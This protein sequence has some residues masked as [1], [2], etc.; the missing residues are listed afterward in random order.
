LNVEAPLR[1]CTVF[2]R[3]THFFLE[4]KMHKRFD[5]AL[6]KIATAASLVVLVGPAFA[7]QY[8]L[9][10]AVTLPLTSTDG[11]AAATPTTYTTLSSLTQ[12]P[13]ANNP[14]GPF[15]SMIVGSLIGTTNN[16][17]AASVGTAFAFDPVN[18]FR[19]I[20]KYTVT[21]KGGHTNPNVRA[22]NNVGQVVGT[23][24]IN[25][26]LSSDS[27]SLLG[28]DTWLYSTSDG[29]NISLG[30]TGPNF[31]Y[32]KTVPANGTVTPVGFSAPFSTSN[33]SFL[34]NLGQVVGTTNRFAGDS[35]PTPSTSLGTSAWLYSPTSATPITEVGLLDSNHEYNFV[36]G[37]TSG[38]FSTN[39]VAGFTDTGYMMGSATAFY[40]VGNGTGTNL[41]SDGWV[42]NGSTTTGIGLYL[43]GIAP[44][45]QSGVPDTY[46]YYQTPTTGTLGTTP[47]T[48]QTRGSTLVGI[49][50]AGQVIGTS[51]YYS[52]TSNGFKGSDAFV[53]S[54][55]NGTYRQLG[56]F[57]NGFTGSA[58]PVG[59]TSYVS[60]T[61]N[62]TSTPAYIN[63]GG[64]IV[65]TSTQYIYYNQNNVSTVSSGQ[66]AWIDGGTGPTRIGLF[67]QVGD[68]STRHV[69]PQTGVTS[70]SITNLTDSGLV[71]GFSSR[72]Y[73]ASNGTG[74]QYGQDAWV[75][76]SNTGAISMVA[77]AAA[78]NDIFF[79]SSITYLSE[80]G[81]A[82]GQYSM[83]ATQSSSGAVARAFLWSLDG[84]FVDLGTSLSPALTASGYQNLI[85]G[86]YS[87][88]GGGTL[89]ASA[90]N[91]VS[92]TINGI[93]TLTP[94]VPEP[95]SLAIVAGVIPLLHRRRRTV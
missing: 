21:S 93:V 11:T 43:R 29:S 26:T 72:Y 12:I 70:A 18:G 41:G 76:N 68:P 55:P 80:D 92:T 57:S 54:I 44:D 78:L 71:G 38:R 10:P 31:S 69:N 81:Y 24:P 2:L 73:L 25:S 58:P 59:A 4:K 33:P 52:A 20:G 50:S 95:T 74:T 15:G 87:T 89:Y 30:L 14:N 64:Q 1:R 6:A 51:Q 83:T 27:N 19:L 91:T 32:T 85:N 77:P 66:V 17:A 67:G 86:F 28:T 65:G 62:R 45:I 40:D 88:S 42:S 47:A 46:H 75:Y 35:M 49:N 36:S 5:R 53:Y 9:N 56:F 48:S 3:L 63:A 79:S 60:T 90:S 22:I 23:S 16:A 94:A 13:R 61:G 34:N 7:Q 39:S 8:Q 84:G 37:G 82:V